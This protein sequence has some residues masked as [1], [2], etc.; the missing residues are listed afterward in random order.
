MGRL[1]GKIAVITGA[2]GAIG[3]AT[4]RK[5]VSEGAKVLVVDREG[6]SVARMAEGLGGDV[7]MACAA[8]V[9]NEADVIRYFATA[10]NQFGGVDVVI[11]NAGIEGTVAPLEVQEQHD[12]DRVLAVNARGVW[13]AIK[14]AVPLLR[15]RGGGS[16]VA[17]SSVAGLVG[18]AGLGPYV[19]SKHAVMGLVRTAALELA[20]EGIRV[21]AVNPGPV[22]NPMMRHVERQA[23]PMGR[24]A[25][26]D[27][28]AEAT[29]FLASP[30]STFV[31]GVALPVDG[32]FVVG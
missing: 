15:L 22:D 12:F 1:D 24:Y 6:K 14:H 18:S 27:E 2:A 10:R 7:A 25:T 28:V 13:L 26:N 9:S 4:A 32:G 5:F 31:T 19:A 20:P 17:T 16:I 8:D 21:N 29:L 11:A 30:Q 23:N 3:S